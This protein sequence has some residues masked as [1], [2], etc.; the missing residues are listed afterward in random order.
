MKKENANFNTLNINI[1]LIKNTGHSKETAIQI[2]C[3]HINYLIPI[4]SKIIQYLFNDE[5]W[6]KIEQT[7]VEENGKTYDIIKVVRLLD[8]GETENIEFWFD[9]SEC[10]GI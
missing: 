2:I 5:P 10:F 9:I 7:I 8:N 4:Q 1:P 6:T 3:P